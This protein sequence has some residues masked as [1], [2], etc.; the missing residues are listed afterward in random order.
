MT[1]PLVACDLDR[2]LIY[3]R[4]AMRLG[5]P[6]A[7]PVCVE[8]YDGRETSFASAAALAGL[9][10]LSRRAELVPTTT[11]TEQQLL[12]VSLPGVRV[13]Y[14]VATNGGC[15]LVDGVRCPDWDDEVSR[16]LAESASY[17]EAAT[18]LEGLFSR[19]WVCKVRDA[20]RRFRY[21]V[22]DRPRVDPDWYAELDETAAGLGWTASVQGRKAYV[23][24][25]QL[26]KEA[27][28]AEVVRR[29]GASLRLAAGD[30]L[31]DR[32]M[33]AWADAAIRP[34]HG[35]LHEAG[36]QPVGV[37]V[38]RRAGGGAAEEIVAWLADTVENAVAGDVAGVHYG[39]ADRL[40]V[41]LGGA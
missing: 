16:R 3:S 30:S 19:P 26:T 27:A 21:A 32:G 11:R 33:L 24:P 25:R 23:V 1:R 37:R 20:E 31:L 35:E 8:V 29:A 15:L 4:A 5:E 2:T 6:V 14:A 9:A 36:W 34:A 40:P 38:T 13:R 17:D 22:L 7:H 18:A 12:R 28:L 10:G 39:G 41:Q